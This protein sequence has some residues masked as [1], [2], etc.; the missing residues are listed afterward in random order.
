MPQALPVKGLARRHALLAEAADALAVL[1][2]PGE[3]LHGLMV[4]TFDLAHLLTAL[5]GRLGSVERLRVAALSYNGRNLRELVGLLDGGAVRAL[6]PVC[7]CFF[8]DQNRE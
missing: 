8:R 6:A 3:V 5:V 1:P 2:G 4:G 7:S